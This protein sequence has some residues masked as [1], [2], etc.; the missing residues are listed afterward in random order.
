MAEGGGSSGGRKIVSEINLTPLIDTLLVLLIVFMVTAPAITRT[1]G[2]KLPKA[3]SSTAPRTPSPS[4]EIDFLTVGLKPNGEV[5][6]E[7]KEYSLAEF[8]EQ[9]PNHVKDRKLEKIFL[10]ADQTV[11]YDH[12]VKVMVYLRDQGHE[13]VGL[14]FEE[15][16]SVQGGN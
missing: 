1:V 6:V 5:I 14:V 16:V 9:F 11:Q 10:Q 12:L 8:F 4:A 13:N 15:K 7:N 3:K 2:V